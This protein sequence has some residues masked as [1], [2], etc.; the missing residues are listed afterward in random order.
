MAKKSAEIR[1]TRHL[2]LGL[3]LATLA[4][5]SF[6]NETVFR[7]MAKDTHIPIDEIR[8]HR[9]TGCESAVQF[10]MNI[11]SLYAY[12]ETDI[13]L[14]T[15]YQKLQRRLSDSAE[16]ES[17]KNAQ[18]AWIAFRDANCKFQTTAWSG[19][20]FRPTANAFCLKGMTEERE[21]YLAGALQ[22]TEPQCPVLSESEVTPNSSATK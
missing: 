21:R 15:T 3:V 9:K 8:Q 7:A 10:H 19:G 12:Y 20:S 5:A 18:R 13:R 2:T 6:A 16:K 11:C 1:A 14:N 22:C 17:L 4:S